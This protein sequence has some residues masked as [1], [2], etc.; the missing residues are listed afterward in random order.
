MAERDFLLGLSDRVWINHKLVPPGT[1][2]G[3]SF[4]YQE[5]P[6]IMF[7]R[8]DRRTATYRYDRH[9]IQF[10]Y[11]NR[12]NPKRTDLNG[13]HA[14]PRANHIFK[15]SG[16]RIKVPLVKTQKHAYADFNQVLGSPEYNRD[17]NMHIG[18][19]GC[20]LIGRDRFL[21]AGFSTLLIEAKEIVY[22][23]KIHKIILAISHP[24]RKTLVICQK[25][26]PRTIAGLKFPLEGVGSVYLLRT[27]A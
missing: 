22:P 15:E 25:G 3:Y 21:E 4:P 13:G 19:D 16:Q 2:D 20:I 27:A 14:D 5:D 24:T 26:R 6:V 9:V 11:T 1:F 12:F 10:E 8:L 23:F 17:T 18:S 7:H